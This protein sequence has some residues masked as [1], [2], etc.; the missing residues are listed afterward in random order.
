MFIEKLTT[1][2]VYYVCWLTAIVLSVTLHELGHVFAALRQG[3]DT[4]R[5]LG[6]V[7]LDP[8]VHM[9]WASLITAALLGIA[10][11]VTPVNPNAFRSRYGRAIVAFGGP[12]VN[13]L[14]AL[15]AFTALALMARHGGPDVAKGNNLWFFVMMLGILNLLLF[16]FNMLPI[17]PLDGATIL[18]NFWPGFDRL[19][20]LPEA[21][22]W[23]FSAILAAAILLVPKMTVLAVKLAALYAGLWR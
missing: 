21:Q 16:L 14:L 7:T 3:D 13:L 5:L 1:D 10:W 19:R 22:P 20:Y 8:L 12:L 15:I 23:F 2:P 11:G 4:P 18:G 17:P 9:G 6:R